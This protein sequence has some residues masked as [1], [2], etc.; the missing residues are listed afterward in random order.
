L[1]L[2]CSSA[3]LALS[4]FCFFRSNHGNAQQVLPFFF[5]NC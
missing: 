4:L 5:N 1:V 3:L 2:H